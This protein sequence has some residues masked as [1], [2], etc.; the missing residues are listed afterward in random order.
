[1][2]LARIHE[3]ALAFFETNAF[4]VHEI[5]HVSTD[6]VGEFEVDMPMAFRA[7]HFRAVGLASPVGDRHELIWKTTVLRKFRLFRLFVL[8]DLHVT[9]V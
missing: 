7:H 9:N 2:Q 6:D 8:S 1:M 3:N 4:A 5:P